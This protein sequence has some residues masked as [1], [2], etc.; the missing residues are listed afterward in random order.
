[1]L[2]SDG[3]GESSSA[4]DDEARVSS[5]RWEPHAEGLGERSSSSLLPA[6]GTGGP[7]G[8][9]WKRPGGCGAKGAVPAGP[10]P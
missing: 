3:A 8:G 7:D 5:S 2:P 9:G 6:S 10:A 1:M 4:V